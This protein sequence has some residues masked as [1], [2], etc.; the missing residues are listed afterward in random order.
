MLGNLVVPNV[1]VG[2]GST[3]TSGTVYYDFTGP[4][5]QTTAVSGPLILNGTNY[6][7]GAELGVVLINNGITQPLY[8]GGSLFSTIWCGTAAP[9]QIYN[10]DI[11]I[12]FTCISVSPVTV[13]AAQATAV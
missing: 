13:Y 1:I 2:V 9:L 6:R 8:F 5:Y 12:A 11:L 7:V 3:A 4:S 10:K